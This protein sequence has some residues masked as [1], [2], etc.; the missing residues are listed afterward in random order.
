MSR[1]RESRR[2]ASRVFSESSG[3][4]ARAKKRRAAKLAVLLILLCLIVIGCYL[5][6][7]NTLIFSDFFYDFYYTYLSPV[8]PPKIPQSDGNSQGELTIHFVDVGQGDSIILELPDGKKMIVDGGPRSAK[9]QLLSYIDELGITRFDY[10]LLTHTDE[11]HVGSLDDVLDHCDV[12]QMLVPDISTD[13]ITTAV[14]RQFVEAAESELSEVE[15][16]SLTYTCYDS[17]FSDEETGYF[18]DFVTPSAADYGTVTAGNAEKINSISPIMIISFGGYRIML[19]G[20]A[21]EIS[22]E[23]FLERVAADTANGADY[24]D[25]DV[26]KVGHHGSETST[27]DTEEIPFLRTIRPEYAVISYGEGNKYGHPRPE[28]LARLAQYM[29]EDHIYGTA[30]DGNIVLKIAKEGEAFEMNF[31]TSEESGGQEAALGLW[32]NFADFS[33][34]FYLSARKF[35][36]F[37]ALI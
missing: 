17:D 33:K 12:V 14:Y 5:W 1:K 2:R 10:L 24:Y 27:N 6:D 8:T 37:A 28:L 19:T 18:V 29:P 34:L 16:S 31:Y 9:A 30:E 20:D 35:Q 21:N 26:L 15:G 22:E 11:D 32:A 13:L 3:G 23:W 7:R 25:V 36:P 4:R